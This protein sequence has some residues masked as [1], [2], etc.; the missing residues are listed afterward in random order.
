M[1]LTISTTHRPATDLGYLLHKNPARAHSFDL[2]FG[3]A[4]VLFPDADEDLC[5]AALLV[6]VDTLT[7]SQ[8]A[9]RSGAGNS[10]LLAQY[11]NDR[12]Y[13]ASSFLSVAMT[14]VFGTTMAG[15]CRERPELVDT[16][17]QLSITVHAVPTSPELAQRLFGPLGYEVNTERS[18]RFTGTQ[19]EPLRPSGN[20]TIKQE[21]PLRSALEHIYVLIPVMDNRKHYWVGPDEVTKLLNRAGDWLPAHPERDLIT[22]RYLRYRRALT[23]D[24]FER[25][26]ELDSVVEEAEEEE[27]GEEETERAERLSDARVRVVTEELLKC[28]A[29]NV[30]DLGCGEGRLLGH[31]RRETRIKRMLGVDASSRSL[32]IASRRLRLERTDSERSRVHLIHGALT[33]ADGRLRGFDAAVAMEVVEHVDLDR[34]PAFERAVFESAAPG[35]VIVTT[36]NREYNSVYDGMEPGRLRHKDHRFEFTRQEFAAWCNGV[37]ER[38][39]YLV[40]VSGIG[41]VHEE[42]GAPTQLAVFSK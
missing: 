7:L 3:T 31:L 6:D 18:D 20:L 12:P 19:L 38:N 32:E 21:I 39:G 9:R 16:P 37:A 29:Q 1:L 13:A 40:E 11:V 36:P 25:L 15:R 30:L 22:K 17:I 14:D 42:L 35:T 8:R 10:E 34:L 26:E 5:T 23:Q 41:E 27:G 4:H 28:G 33:Y 2:K 24:A